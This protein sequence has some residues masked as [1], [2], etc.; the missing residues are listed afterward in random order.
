MKKVE[1]ESGSLR[2][3][4]TVRSVKMSTSAAPSN[5]NGRGGSLQK[6]IISMEEFSIFSIYG[7]EGRDWEWKVYK[8]D[9]WSSLISLFCRGMLLS[10]KRND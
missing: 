8:P 2:T 3:N 5:V 9:K 4:T 7:N 6:I 1:K 10:L